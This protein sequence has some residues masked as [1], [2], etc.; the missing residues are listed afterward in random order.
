M[1]LLF[2]TAL[3]LVWSLRL[4]VIKHLGEGG[5]PPQFIFQFG[6]FGI[7]SLMFLVLVIRGEKLPI[8]R[9]TA[10]FF[11]FSGV[12]GFLLP[13]LTESFVAPNISVFLFIVIITTMPMWTLLIVAI[14]GTETLT[15]KKVVALATGFVA[16]SMI[17][18]DG[19]TFD[20]TG[21][22][23]WILAAFVLPLCFAANATFIASRWPAGVSQSQ[24]ACGQ[25]A[26]AL[27]G[28]VSALPFTDALANLPLVWSYAPGLA[29]I[30]GLEGLGL[31]F[32][33]GLTRYSGAT[34]VSYANYIALAFGAL[35]GFV[36]FNETFGMPTILAV[37]LLVA[38]LW[39]MRRP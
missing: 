17:V 1:K 24:A 21:S 25:S 7:A 14:A 28:V 20:L 12:F 6:V 26:I 32:F 13:F 29:A 22:T 35:W 37:G 27:L 30:V 39:M 38:A 31:L 9:G 16:V 15:V 2:L 11:V 10:P 23:P 36:I 18:L 5:L 8:G 19:Q 3:G 4:V 34:F 33:L